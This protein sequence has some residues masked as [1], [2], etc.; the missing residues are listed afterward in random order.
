MQLR[1]ALPE[2]S[3][4]HVIWLFSDL[5]VQLLATRSDEC[6]MAHFISGCNF[7]QLN[8]GRYSGQGFTEVRAMVRRSTK[9]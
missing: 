8:E 2:M 7:L 1:A 9:I 4:L 5:Q 3:A 6:R